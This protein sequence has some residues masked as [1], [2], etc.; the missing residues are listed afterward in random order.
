M[1]VSRVT[2]DLNRNSNLVTLNGQPAW[3]M[4]SHLPSLGDWQM[5]SWM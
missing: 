1:V 2:A 3:Q 5:G 4:Y